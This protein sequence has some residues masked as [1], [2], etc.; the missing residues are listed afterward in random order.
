MILEACLSTLVIINLHS[1]G[2]DLLGLKGANVKL[3]VFQLA[4]ATDLPRISN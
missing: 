2:G 1:F 3:F 4:A